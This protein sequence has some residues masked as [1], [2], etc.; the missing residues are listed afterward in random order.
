MATMKKEKIKLNQAGEFFSPLDLHFAA[1]MEE[2]SGGDA[3]GIWLAAALVSRHREDGHVCIDLAGLAETEIPAGASALGCPSLQPWLKELR[4]SPVVGKPG[5]YRPLIL[6]GSRLYLHRYWDDEN[7]AAVRLR[8]DA[9]WLNENLNESVFRDGL[10]RLFP[11]AGK[12]VPDLQKIAAALSV[13]KRFTVISGGPG[14]GKTTTVAKI[15]ALLLEQRQPEQSAVAPLRIA[16]CAPTGK[17]AARLQEAINWEKS[18]LDCAD[19]VR[20]AIP[21]QASTIHRLLSSFSGGRSGFDAPDLSSDA[22]GEFLPVDVLVIDEASMVD[23]SLLAS[24]LKRLPPGA[25]LILLGDKDQLASVEAGS[26]LADICGP[27]D[28][29]FSRNICARLQAFTSENLPENVPCDVPMG[30]CIVQLQQSYRFGEDSGIGAVSRLINGGDADGALGTLQGESYTDAGSRFLPAPHGLADM[31]RDAV[32]KGFLPYLTSA[33]PAEAL[34]ALS[35]FRI[36]CAFREGPYGVRALNAVIERILAEAGLIRHDEA[37]YCG[38]PVL[39]TRNDYNLRLFNG[40]VGIILPDT[41]SGHMRAFFQDPDGA[42]RKFPP[43]RLPDHETVYAMTV[44]KSQG[45]EFEKVVFI[46]PDRA[47]PVLTRE[48]LYTAMTRAKTQAEIWMQ[49]EVFKTAIGRRIE[50]MSGLAE[51]LWKGGGR[52][53]R[54]EA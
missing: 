14:T 5:E 26:I 17:A 46:L 3:P 22:S 25:R 53:V 54:R 15:L 13:L 32:V 24:V 41:Q 47:S 21:S 19:A 18:R 43:L 2:L 12:D 23:I 29:G 40:D 27:G 38:R 39:I 8:E 6:D 1:L 4:R 51:A 50:R 42:I 16:L 28:C 20:D 49:E 34:G 7:Q 10:D 30:D 11:P 44:H 52:R 48:L 31:L 33:D 45:S 35:R 37:F 36:L 9:A